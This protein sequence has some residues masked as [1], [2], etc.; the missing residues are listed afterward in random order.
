[1]TY[2]RI[3]IILIIGI[4][5]IGIMPYLSFEHVIPNLIFI[6]LITNILLGQDQTALW[7]LVLG[8]LILELFS[9][10]PFG[11][12]LL[13]YLI[14]YIII[15]YLLRIYLLEPPPLLAMVV[16]FAASLLYNMVVMIILRLASFYSLPILAITEAIL[17]G[18]IYF[19]TWRRHIQ[20]SPIK[21]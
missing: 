2:W 3:F 8:G 19:I 20:K 4:I 11:L 5:Q 14:I 16:F 21:I 12:Y 9:P 17:G 10:L 6:I 7:W 13:P 1:M 15:R 18:L